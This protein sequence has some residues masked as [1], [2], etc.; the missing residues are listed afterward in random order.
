MAISLSLI[1]LESR[2]ETLARSGRKAAT[3]LARK[4][5]ILQKLSRFAGFLFGKVVNFFNLDFDRIWD[6]LIDG[7]FELKTFDWNAMDSELQKQIEANNQRILT[8]GAAT[9]GNYL[10]WSAFRIATF[11]G[12]KIGLRNSKAREAAKDFKV[13][14]L[15]GRVG[16]ALAEEGNE[17]LLFNMRRF[18]T[19]TLSAQLSNSFIRFVLTARRNEWFGQQ[20]ITVPQNNGSIA[21]KIEE[22]IEKLPKFWQRPVE[23]LIDEF[24][25]GIIEAGYV[26]AMTIDDYV[27][28]NK[29]SRKEAG[30]YRTLELKLE[31]GS[32]EKLEFR[33]NQLDLIDAVRT[34][35]PVRQLIADRDVGQI[36][37]SDAN[38]F[39]SLKPQL[40]ML[41][42]QFHGKKQPPFIKDRK[43]LCS[44]A[45][46]SIPDPKAGLSRNDL[47]KVARPYQRGNW[48]VRCELDSGRQMAGWFQSKT[49]GIQALTELSA[50]S[51]TNIQSD[52]FRWSEG[53]S[54]PKKSERMYPTHGAVINPKRRN[55]QRTGPLGK[56]ERIP[57]WGEG[58]N[59]LP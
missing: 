36:L 46:I 47:L 20:S 31:S 2:K 19:T 40:R 41:K 28:A 34:T 27:A 4:G 9:L 38:E 10:G 6:I 33:G 13:P 8:A 21:E 15:A 37:G 18:V 57:L 43:R 51:T 16:L 11:F 56:A 55:G 53:Q 25:D 22:K 59:P 17:E 42:I 14:V 26:V 58:D 23:T 5:G 35:L 54:A 30:P 7:Y 49:E 50:L 32:D 52:S 45:E 48:Y 12:G 44:V 39:I 24:E 1:S 29:Y 3:K